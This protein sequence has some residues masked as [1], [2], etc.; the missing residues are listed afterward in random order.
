MIDIIYYIN[1]III[2]IISAFWSVLLKL[3]SA[4]SVCIHQTSE[5]LSGASAA[6]A[7]KAA[8][9]AVTVCHENGTPSALAMSNLHQPRC[10]ESTKT[11]A[12]SCA[13][14]V[15]PCLLT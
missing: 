1:Y 14:T 2:S 6:A 13:V 12:R 7:A 10:A 9:I 4:H 3:G 5:P 8:A 15:F 11:C